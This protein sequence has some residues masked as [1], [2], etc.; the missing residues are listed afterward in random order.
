MPLPVEY[1]NPTLSPTRRR[2]DLCRY[3]ESLHRNGPKTGRGR[4]YTIRKYTLEYD[5]VMN[6]QRQEIYGF[7][8]EILH[9]EDLK[10][11]AHNLLAQVCELLAGEYFQSRGHEG[12]WDPEGFPPKLDEPVPS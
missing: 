5:D 8:N 4:N 7:R 6:K 9:S 12:K 1:P 2:A 11:T 10:P 3:P